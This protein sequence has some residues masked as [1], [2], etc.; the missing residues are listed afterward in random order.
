MKAKIFTCCSLTRCEDVQ[1]SIVAAAAGVVVAVAVVV[2]PVIVVDEVAWT[3]EK[4]CAIIFAS[5]QN[6]GAPAAEEEDSGASEFVSE[7]FGGRGLLRRGGL[8][9][10]DR[11]CT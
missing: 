11:P 2:D 4:F 6:S 7:G 1:L 9:V 3:G 10:S 5:E 8:P